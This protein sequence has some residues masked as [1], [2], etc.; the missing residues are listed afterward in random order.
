M[1]LG[2][3][4]AQNASPVSGTGTINDNDGAP[5]LSISGPADVN[6]AAGTI[7]YTVSL[8]NASASPV[9]VN[10]ATADGTATAGADYTASTGTLSFAPGETSKTITVPI[11]NDATYE[12]AE[13]YSV[14]LSAPTGATIASGSVTTTIH[15]DGTGFVPPRDPGR[16]PSG[17]SQCQQPDGDRRGTAGLHGQPDPSEHHADCGHT[18]PGQRHGHPGHRHRPGASQLR[19][20]GELR[21]GG[22]QHGHGTGRGHR[23][24]RA[25]PD[26][27]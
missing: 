20:R 4:T 14:G 6:E 18:E 16:R 9:T 12:G 7:S 3:A 24:H 2:A 25:L 15:D 10:Y 13:T 11:T 26:G 17:G 21:P 22:G 5:Q 8:T 1:T 19:R 27:R 23:L